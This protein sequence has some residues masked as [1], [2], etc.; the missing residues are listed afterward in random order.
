MASHWSD[1]F[2][3][4]G[5]EAESETDRRVEH[6][7]DHAAGTEDHH[8]GKRGNG[9]RV[10]REPTGAGAQTVVRADP[11][12]T[13]GCGLYRVAESRSALYGVFPGSQRQGEVGKFLGWCQPRRGPRHEC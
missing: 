7:G 6:D 9:E 13:A 2:L 10:Y 3:E 4:Q 11:G 1:L 5:D 8:R 12:A